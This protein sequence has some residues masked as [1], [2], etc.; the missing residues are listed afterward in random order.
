MIRKVYTNIFLFDCVERYKLIE[1]LPNPFLEPTSIK[2]WKFLAQGNNSLPL[3]GFE[4]TRSA[5]IILLVRRVKN[6]AT[7]ALWLDCPYNKNCF[8][9]PCVSSKFFAT[10][11]LFQSTEELLEYV[12][13][14]TRHG[15]TN[16]IPSIY[17]K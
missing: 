7:P 12:T 11:V 6:S 4:P 10:F 1:T 13:I 16:N 2:Q 5:I 17:M 3:T 9:Y 14:M 15:I 8:I